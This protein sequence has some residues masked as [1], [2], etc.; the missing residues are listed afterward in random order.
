MKKTVHALD[1]IV[2][3]VSE[4]LHLFYYLQ[5]IVFWILGQIYISVHGEQ[6]L[7]IQSAILAKAAYW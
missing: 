1:Y 7:V 4:Q 5:V 6:L 2:T 3:N